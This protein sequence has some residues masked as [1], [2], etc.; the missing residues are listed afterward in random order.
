MTRIVDELHSSCLA[1]GFSPIQEKSNETELIFINAYSE[2]AVI[3]NAKGQKQK[4]KTGTGV[5]EHQI[6]WSSSA[7]R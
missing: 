4:P 6:V 5:F 2:E 3:L 1:A 7:K